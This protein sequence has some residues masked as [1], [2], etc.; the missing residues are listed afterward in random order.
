MSQ[1]RAIFKNKN[2]EKPAA[3][4]AGMDLT[5]MQAL[6]THRCFARACS[7]P[8]ARHTHTH[9]HTES[10]SRNRSR[11]CPAARALVRV[12]QKPGALGKRRPRVPVFT[13]TELS[14]RRC[15]QAC[16]H[17]R[18]RSVYSAF[19][20]CVRLMDAFVVSVAAHRDSCSAVGAG[21]L[22]APHAGTP[23][24]HSDG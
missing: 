10:A 8:S 21:Q 7:P 18:L 3:R 12:W 19:R 20:V 2:C 6:L 24:S 4:A 1:I 23:A 15:L 5:S 16:L 17:S 11:L 22:L 14:S 13:R 9:T